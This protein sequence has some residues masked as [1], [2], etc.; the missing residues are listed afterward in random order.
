MNAGVMGKRKKK[1]KYRFSFFISHLSDF[2]V[3]QII[4]GSIEMLISDCVPE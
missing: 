4:T 3:E 2:G 1:K